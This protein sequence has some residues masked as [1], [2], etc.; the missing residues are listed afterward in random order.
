[1]RHEG[2]APEFDETG[3]GRGRVGRPE[4]R[5]WTRGRVALLLAA[6]IGPAWLPAIDPLPEGLPMRRARG[7][8]AAPIRRLAFSPDGQ[9]IATV[10]ERGRVRL[11]PSVDGR[12]VERELDVRGHARALAFSPDGQYLAVGRDEP[13]VVQYDLGRGGPECPR[14]EGPPAPRLARKPSP[15]ASSQPRGRFPIP[16]GASPPVPASPDASRPRG[17]GRGC[18]RWPRRS[19]RE[20]FGYPRR[21]SYRR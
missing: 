5:R 16:P 14:R 4:F 9:T 20:P 8:S 11:R 17:S 1:M 10:D 2:D 18:T 7:D 21:H 19:P 15:R 13:D 12:G 3:P 6:A